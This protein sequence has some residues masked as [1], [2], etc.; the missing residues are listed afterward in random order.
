VELLERDQQEAAVRIQEAGAMWGKAGDLAK[1]AVEELSAAAERIAWLEA[2]LNSSREYAAEATMSIDGS[3]DTPRHRAAN[4]MFMPS[5]GMDARLRAL[6]SLEARLEA[7]EVR[8]WP[9]PSE[10]RA[11]LHA[12]AAE[13]G[14][15]LRSAH[16]GGSPASRSRE[17]S[18][19]RGKGS[20]RSASP[21]RSTV[22]DVP[23]ITSTASAP[24]QQSPSKRLP[25][26]PGR[27][28]RPAPVVGGPVAGREKGDSS[29]VPPSGGTTTASTRRSGKP[30]AKPAG[31]G[32]WRF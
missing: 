5:D 6:R 10:L 11:E 25:V 2:E 1:R 15:L 20:S 9:E 16:H 17:T 28:G 12:I 14:A 21:A 3:A 18:F 8:G 30:V 22:S 19:R 32:R 4:A 7:T 26:T 31:G 27:P 29:A 24:V 23:S 13:V